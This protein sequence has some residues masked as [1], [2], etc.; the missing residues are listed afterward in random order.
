MIKTSEDEGKSALK[1]ALECAYDLLLQKIISN[2][3]DMMGILLFGTV[4]ICN[5]RQLT[6]QETTKVEGNYA[7]L[8]NLMDLDVPDA[9]GIKELKR[10]LNGI[11]HSMNLY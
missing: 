11:P 6:W 1:T 8:Y 9:S 2:P 4:D 3:N 7:H 10:I 5:P